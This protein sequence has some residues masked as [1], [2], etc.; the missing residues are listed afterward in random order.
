[1]RRVVDA[2]THSLTA[3]LAGTFTPLEALHRPSA[4]SLPG[5]PPTWQELDGRW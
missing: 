1:M 4:N 2:D 3:R 5:P